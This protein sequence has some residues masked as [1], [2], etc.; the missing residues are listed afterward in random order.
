M[1]GDTIAERLLVLYETGRD[2]LPLVYSVKD[3]LSG[4]NRPFFLAE[5]KFAKLAQAL[6]KDFPDTSKLDKVRKKKKKKKIKNF[7]KILEN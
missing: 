7:W 3:K 5:E 2:L 4:P 1:G 6:V